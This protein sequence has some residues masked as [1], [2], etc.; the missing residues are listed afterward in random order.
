MYWQ[1]NICLYSYSCPQKHFSFTVVNIWK[2]NCII[3]NVKL[4]PL[5]IPIPLNLTISCHSALRTFG[6]E[7]NSMKSFSYLISQIHKTFEHLL[8]QPCVLEGKDRGVINEAADIEQW[9]VYLDMLLH[10]VAMIVLYIIYI[11]SMIHEVHTKITSFLKL[12]QSEDE[13]YVRRQSSVWPHWYMIVQSL[14]SQSSYL[15]KH[16]VP[17]FLDSIL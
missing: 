13:N 10:S 16:T 9:Q 6:N 4:P 15:T 1:I 3:F 7:S 11:F 2:S 12:L 14:H 8:K 5:T 17:S